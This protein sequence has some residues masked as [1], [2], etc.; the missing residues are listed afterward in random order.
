MYYHVVTEYIFTDFCKRGLDRAQSYRKDYP[1]PKTRAYRIAS[2]VDPAVVCS[3]AVTAGGG[4][5]ELKFLPGDN[6]TPAGRLIVTYY[7]GQGN[8]APAH[9]SY[10]LVHRGFTT[11]L[12]STVDYAIYY[13]NREL[14]F[15]YRIKA[16]HE[17]SPKRAFR[18]FVKSRWLLKVQNQLNSDP[19]V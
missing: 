14:P 5:P 2:L 19:R 16:R 4:V 18:P 9:L 12:N 10:H 1:T 15:I 8:K 17:C 11:S 13:R 7:T 3:L 6:I